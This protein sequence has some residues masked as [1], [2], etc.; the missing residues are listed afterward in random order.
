MRRTWLSSACLIGLLAIVAPASSS[1]EQ[2]P[3]A[4]HE[5]AEQAE[6]DGEGALTLDRV[7]HTT[8]FWGTLVNFGFL[9]IVLTWAIRKKG[10][11]ALRERAEAVKAELDEAQ[12][13]RAE[14]QAKHDEAA[15]RLEQLDR[16]MGQIRA[17]MTKAGEIERDRMVAQ[18]EEKA[19]RM[20]RDATF[21]IEQQVKQLRSDLTHEATRAAIDAAEQILT[22]KTND[23]DQRRLASDYLNRLVE[24]TS[25]RQS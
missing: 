17:E 10:N 11:P 22:A 15:A 23:D 1:A 14:A 5:A 24:V 9:I 18:A 20:R 21:L 7:L 13:L 3:S 16:E 4:A 19:A 12:R 6:P 2:H 25:E 8:E